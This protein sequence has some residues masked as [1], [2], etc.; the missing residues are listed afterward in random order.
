MSV[1]IVLGFGA[2]VLL[3]LVVF[4]LGGRYE[5]VNRY[6]KLHPKKRHE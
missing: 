5:R 2:L 3:Y 4:F 1:R 6:H